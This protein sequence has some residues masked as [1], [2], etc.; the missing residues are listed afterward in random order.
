MH[1]SAEGSIVAGSFTP[2]YHQTAQQGLG[3]MMLPSCMMY[4]NIP[5]LRATF[6]T[7]PR[8][9]KHNQLC[10][11]EQAVT[12]VSKNSKQHVNGAVVTGGSSSLSFS[13]QVWCLGWLDMNQPQGVDELPACSPCPHPRYRLAMTLPV[14]MA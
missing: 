6:A 1:T 9:M 13:L 11:C 3:I 2:S 10:V 4:S 14:L 12:L 7:S 5:V 8:V